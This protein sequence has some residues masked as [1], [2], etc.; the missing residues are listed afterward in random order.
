MSHDWV[1]L[2]ILVFGLF[3]LVFLP[4]YLSMIFLLLFLVFV[5]I[6]IFRIAVEQGDK[7]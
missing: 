4:D 7:K 3:L 1:I 5:M 6:L 2:P